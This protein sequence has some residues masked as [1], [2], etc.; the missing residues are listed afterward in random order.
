ME[1][2][3]IKD[4]KRYLTLLFI[5]FFSC[6][7]GFCSNVI[8]KDLGN[9]NFGKFQAVQD[10]IAKINS[11]QKAKSENKNKKTKPQKSKEKKYKNGDF[12][13]GEWVKGKPHGA[14]KM[15]YA[16]GSQY[17]GDW[18]NGIPS[19]KGK[20][21]YN[22]SDIYEGEFQNGK[23]CGKGKMN[24]YNGDTFI[25]MFKDGEPFGN[26]TMSF[27][28]LGE[29]SFTGEWEGRKLKNRT[30]K[31]SS[32]NHLF[33]GSANII[34]KDDRIT[35]PADFSPINGTITT[36]YFSFSGDFRNNIPYKGK[37]TQKDS[38]K[39][40]FY[41][42]KNNCYYEGEFTSSLKWPEI[43]KADKYKFE[44][45]IKPT[46]G[47]GS[48]MYLEPQYSGEYSARFNGKWINSKFTG[49]I[50]N[51]VFFKE[52]DDFGASNIV[53]SEDGK[54]IAELQPL[55]VGGPTYKGEFKYGKLNG[56]G[57]LTRPEQKL[58]M[59]GI[60]KNGLFVEGEVWEKAGNGYFYPYT[61]KNGTITYNGTDGKDYYFY[62]IQPLTTSPN[63][64]KKYILDIENKIAYQNMN[65][66]LNKER[67][68]YS[69]LNK[70]S[71]VEAL[72]VFDLFKN[73]RIKADRDYPFGEKM[74]FTTVIDKIDTQWNSDKA[75]FM[76]AGGIGRNI[77]IYSIDNEFTEISYPRRVWFVAEI[78]RFIE[79]L[80]SND[81]LI[82][83]NAVLINW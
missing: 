71:A 37:I 5:I 47:K 83:N 29:W 21:K 3:V 52:M 34:S 24:Y 6:R 32:K 26:G 69:K 78:G 58:R 28:P 65:N 9:L 60:W 36:E 75:Y 4:M 63:I 18:V 70:N 53:V 40:Y 12:Y 48:L 44:K 22:N 27:G 10:S 66:K 38:E 68:S 1:L 30:G 46:N 51:V 74:F 77:T 61:L 39:N 8:F 2:L 7:I 35:R 67:Q 25:G 82:L 13:S 11:E 62:N 16:D 80:F 54:I 57:S 59:N 33:E 73:N 17:E 72:N 41:D 15:Q 20:M 14:G 81:E 49:Q 31:V 79:H 19:G 50:T 23:P 76:E 56:E 45:A 42:P 64:Y 43:L 55:T